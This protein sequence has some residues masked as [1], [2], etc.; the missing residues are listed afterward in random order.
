MGPIRD[1]QKAKRFEQRA[2][3][4]APKG[5]WYFACGAPAGEEMNMN[6]VPAG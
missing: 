4:D 5:V 1:V 2:D 3:P 6:D